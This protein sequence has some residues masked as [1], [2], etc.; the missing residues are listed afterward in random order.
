LWE[1]KLRGGRVR[2]ENRLE[3]YTYIHPKKGGGLTFLTVLMG[4][5]LGFY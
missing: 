2:V 4:H 3:Q 1:E 5:Y